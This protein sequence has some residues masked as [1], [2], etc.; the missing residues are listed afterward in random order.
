MTL[1]DTV[2]SAIAELV[3]GGGIPASVRTVNLGGEALSRP[4][5][6]ASTGPAASSGC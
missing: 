6:T 5:W 1:I 3:R 2:P 4:W